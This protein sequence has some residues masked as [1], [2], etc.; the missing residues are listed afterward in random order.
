MVRFVTFFVL[1]LALAGCHTTKLGQS[2]G[3]PEP[4]RSYPSNTY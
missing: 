3:F 1:S 4:Q 2:V